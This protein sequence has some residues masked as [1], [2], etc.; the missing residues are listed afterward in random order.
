MATNQL[1]TINLSA[2]PAF[3]KKA[4]PSQLAK[5]LS[6][7]GGGGYSKRLSIRGGVFRLVSEG[8]EIETIEDRHLD[9]VIVAAAPKIARTYYEGEY[10][11]GESKSPDCWSADGDKPHSSVK[12]P[13]GKTCATCPQN[14]KGSGQGDSRACR[15]SQRLGVVLAN[16]PSGMLLQLTLS[17]T[18][19]FGKAEGD[20]RPLQAYAR[21]LAEQGVDPG[22]VVTRMRFD[23]AVA[24]PKLFFRAQRWLTEQEYAACKEQA[25]SEDAKKVIDMEAGASTKPASEPLSLPGKSP[26]ARAESEDEGGVGQPTEPPEE[27]APPVKKPATRQKAAVTK[28]SLADAVSKWADDE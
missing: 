20:N 26:V 6:G 19:I 14:V 24:V 5:A 10:V 8:K 4:E 18:S 22:T 1:Q 27:D 12:T 28:Q 21:W 23:T 15:F 16:D 2:V 9:V 13:Q 7:G 17:A 25:D 3:A 11:E